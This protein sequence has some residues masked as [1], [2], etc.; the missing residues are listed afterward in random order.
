[1]WRKLIRKGIIVHLK[2]TR[3]LLGI[4][5]DVGKSLYPEI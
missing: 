3:I 2:T 1:M 5:A 4:L